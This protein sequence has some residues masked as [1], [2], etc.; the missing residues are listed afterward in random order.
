M[1]TT[2]NILSIV[3]AAGAPGVALLAITNLLPADI[4]LAIIS[5]GGLAAFAALDYSRNTKSLRVP[6]RLLR[7]AL[8]VAANVVAACSVRR[9]A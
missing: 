2:R 8:P 3:I 6:G 9:A 1:K 5:V 7:P 4:A